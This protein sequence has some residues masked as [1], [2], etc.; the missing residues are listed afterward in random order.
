MSSFILGNKNILLPESWNLK[1]SMSQYCKGTSNLM[2]SILKPFLKIEFPKESELLFFLLSYGIQYFPTVQKKTWRL[3]VRICTVF[4]Q[5][6][7]LKI[8]HA[9]FLL[10]L[11]LCQNLKR[12]SEVVIKVAKCPVVFCGHLSGSSLTV[13]KY[14]LRLKNVVTIWGKSCQCCKHVW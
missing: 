14:D 7:W 2:V 13:I 6:G 10:W 11:I 12:C 4:L 8:I 3:K 9:F 5:F 1:L